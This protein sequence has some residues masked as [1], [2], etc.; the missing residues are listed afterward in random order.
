MNCEGKT[1][2]KLTLWLLVAVAACGLAA[3]VKVSELPSVSS[4]G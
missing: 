3:S 1:M 4:V 2:K